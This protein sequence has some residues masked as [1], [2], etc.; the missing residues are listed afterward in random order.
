MHT[1]LN[2]PFH[3][4]SL[5]YEGM[6]WFLF[7]SIAYYFIDQTQNLYFQYYYYYLESHMVYQYISSCFASL[8]PSLGT[9]VIWF[10]WFSQLNFHLMLDL[11]FVKIRIKAFQCNG[12]LSLVIG[13]RHSYYYFVHEW[14]LLTC[15][16]SIL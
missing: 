13:E 12:I 8:P 14:M 9:T 11:Y 6:H 3:K 15:N 7:V 4:R 5:T 1:W 16:F 10:T 2:L